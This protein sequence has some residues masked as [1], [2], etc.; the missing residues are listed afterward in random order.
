MEGM[1]SESTTLFLRYRERGDLVAL[2][3]VFDALAPRLLGLAL[4][5]TGGGADAEDLVQRTFLVAMEKAHDFDASRELEPWLTGILTGEAR[6][7]VRRLRRQASVVGNLEDRSA[8]DRHTRQGR[9]GDGREDGGLDRDALPGAIDTTARAI[10]HRELVRLV[11]L[12]VDALPHEQR[13]V[14]LLKL[15]HGLRPAEISEVLAIPPGAVRMRLHRGLQ[16]L[17]ERLPKSWAPLLAVPVPHR[18]LDIVRSRV[19]DAGARHAA[20]VPLGS[21]TAI[22]TGGALMIQ[23]VVLVCLGLALLFFA[24]SFAL[25]LFG[26]SEPV[27]QEQAASLETDGAGPIVAP[28]PI[29]PQE[30]Q[31]EERATAATPSIP[32][33]IEVVL[34][35]SDRAEA[36]DPVPIPAADVVLWKEAIGEQELEQQVFDQQ[37][38]ARGRAVAK[39]LAPATYRLEVQLGRESVRTTR[40]VL[41]SGAQHV[42]RVSIKLAGSIRG[43]VVDERGNKVEGAAI[44]VGNRQGYGTLRN[45]VRQVSTSRADGSFDFSYTHRDEYVAASRS[46]HAP[47]LSYPLQ[48]LGGGA[49]RL[50]LGTGHATISGMVVDDLGVAIPKATVVVQHEAETLGRNDD[51]ALV[52][53][54]LPS[55]ATTD[56]AGRFEAGPLPPGRAKC[57]VVCLPWTMVTEVIDIDAGATLTKRFVLARRAT[58]YGRIRDASG[59]PVPRM[60][61]GLRQGRGWMPAISRDDGSYRFEGVTLEPFFLQAT[62]GPSAFTSEEMAHPAPTALET[63]VDLVMPRA[64]AI[65]G[66][67]VDA[68][69][70]GLANFRLAVSPR[71]LETGS[72]ETKPLI[73]TTF[74]DGDFAIYGVSDREYSVRVLL[75][76]DSSTTDGEALAEVVASPAPTP[77]R[78]VVEEPVFGELHGHVLDDRGQPVVGCAVGVFSVSGLEIASATTDERGSYRIDALPRARLR[79]SVSSPEHQRS[80]REIDFRTKRE[81]EL[82]FKLKRAATLRVTYRRPDGSAWTTR[83]P[84]PWIQSGTGMWLTSGRVQYSLEGDEVVVRHVPAGHYTLVAP[85]GDELLIHPEP[86]DLAMGQTRTV[87]LVA[88]VGRRCKLSFEGEARGTKLTVTVQGADVA[89]SE[90]RFEAELS[91]QKTYVLEA[92]LPR[93]PVRITARSDAGETFELA[94]TVRAGAPG[95]TQTI[96]VPRG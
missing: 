38:D 95:A 83:P 50:V 74:D 24:G 19:L 44:L 59:R 57:S 82:D 6:N 85:V 77:I 23:K 35:G 73:V 56:A 7:A 49:I 45:L 61:V 25:D 15:Q 17:R 16:S 90:D 10:E 28:K 2:G 79:T 70:R 29:D 88:R 32:G 37:T 71:R 48:Q 3:R 4:H 62:H 96:V 92:A 47:S 12:N 31:R 63:R 51:G 34:V 1:A 39:D 65:H 52:G 5:L 58:I 27:I 11:R 36:N 87:T 64:L 30:D 89:G 20:S 69:G 75:P 40:I 67:V 54:Y 53:P 94:T 13:Q 68:N 86:V 41:E 80:G 76:T 66:T 21:W 26:T 33:R 60:H 91:K 42:E 43:V 46:G 84:V 9:T 78:I 18:G 93:G 55:I 72:D 8:H 22:G 81:Q 14:V